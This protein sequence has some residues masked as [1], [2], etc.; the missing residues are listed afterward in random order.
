MLIMHLMNNVYFC[1]TVAFSIIGG[2]DVTFLTRHGLRQIDL[3][4]ANLTKN[5]F[6]SGF[7]LVGI[8]IIFM[9]LWGAFQR[10]ETL[11]RLYLWYMLVSFLLDIGFIIQNFV[12]QGPC[13]SLPS[14]IQGAGQAFS[15]GVARGVNGTLIAVM[16]GI[17]IYFIFIV[18][19]FC[20][21][22]AECGM[23]EIGD[24]GK[25]WTGTKLSKADLRRKMYHQHPSFG[26]SVD[27]DGNDG[28]YGALA[29]YEWKQYAGGLFGNPHPTYDYY[30]TQGLGCQKIFRKSDY[31]EMQYPPPADNVGP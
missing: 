7:C 29:T 26:G 31:H 2:P 11:V 30:G 6:I 17:Q 25:D 5:V 28:K 24:L 18:W 8:P 15:C 12:I 3:E 27:K 13:M 23:M 10:A 22:L 19:S 4:T 9:G 21:D 16:L 14:V 1:V 20:E